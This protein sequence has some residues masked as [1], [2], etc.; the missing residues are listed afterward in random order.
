VVTARA[1]GQPDLVQRLLQVDDD[2]AAVGE[3]SV[4]MPPVR[5]LSMSASVCFVDRSQ[6][7]DRCAAAP[8]RGP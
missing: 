8:P 6:Q 2:L 1:R 5:W 4:T 3:T 7:L